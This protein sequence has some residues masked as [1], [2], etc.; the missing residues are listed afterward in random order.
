MQTSQCKKCTQSF[1]VTP[2]DLTFYEKLDVPLPTLCPDCRYRRRLLD[3]NEW[4]LY[5]RKC[6][7]TGE[8]IVSIYR[9]DAPFP[10]YKQ[11]VWRSDAWDPLSYGRDFDF[12]RPFFEQYHELRQAVPHP[13][14]V[15][16][17]SVNSEYSNQ[18]QDN[19]DC[20]MVSATGES[21]KCMYGNW[22]Q[23]AYFCGDCYMLKKCELCYEC[24]NCVRCYSCAYSVDCFDCTSVNFSLDCHGC[25]NCFGCAGLRNKN[26][27]WFNEPLAKEKYKQRL[28][29]FGWNRKL[30]AEMQGKSR[31]LSLRIPHKHYH[32]TKVYQSTGDYIEEM[33]RS[34]LVFNCHDGK[35]NAYLQDSWEI[36]NSLDNTEILLVE[37]SYE[38]QGC[39]HTRNSIAIRSTDAISDSCYC[40]MC[41]S[42]TNCFGCI[43]LKSKE[44]CILNKQY[45]KEEYLSLKKKIIEYMKKTGEWGEYFPPEHSPFA[46]NESVAQDFFPLPKEKALAQGIPWYD[47]PARN[48]QFTLK[49]AELPQ[50]IKETDDSIL[51]QVIQCAT[52][53]SEEEK[54][55]H[56]ACATAFKLI[57]LELA[58][59]R[60]LNIPVPA[61][62]Y[63]CRRIDRFAKRNP[64]RL[65]QRKCQCARE[66]SENGVY[67]NIASHSH[68]HGHC[69]VSLETSY[70][71]EKPEII[72]C[73]SCY[74]S[75]IA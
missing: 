20:Y 17:N 36:N 39:S 42:C 64:R 35:D 61:K 57:P 32:G 60:K 28:T 30:I 16:Y 48:Y 56:P 7:K 5:R 21:E 25:N 72:Y 37:Q 68:G 69:E 75:E 27:Y 54:K 23:P 74:N 22:Y 29:E 55:A 49:A 4:S 47:A 33:E 19:K 43:S 24:M 51:N 3:R 50:T 38:I 59:Y 70:A 67:K 40:D 8:S 45:S 26:Y 41:H 2:D 15:N 71:P 73:E 1:T 14:L 53:E 12:N 65:W 44:Y 11:E 63:P 31:A 18:S 6:S 13:A 58:L 66:Q 62:C 34:R 9:E 46:Y 52:Q 10:V